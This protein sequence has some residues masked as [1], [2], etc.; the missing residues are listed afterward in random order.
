MSKLSRDESL[1][2]TSTS[3]I[4]HRGAGRS[5]GELKCRSISAG[6]PLSNN[7]MMTTDVHLDYN[8]NDSKMQLRAAPSIRVAFLAIGRP[9]PCSN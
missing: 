6:A 3:R 1:G 5:R 2:F 9:E 4:A 7:M 8:Q